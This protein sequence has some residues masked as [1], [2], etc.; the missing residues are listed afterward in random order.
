MLI[1]AILLIIFLVLVV[2]WEKEFNA[3]LRRRR[4]GEPL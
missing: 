4:N 3:R 1:G 2:A